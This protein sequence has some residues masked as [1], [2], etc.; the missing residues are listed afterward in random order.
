MHSVS[1]LLA[2][3]TGG[4][5]LGMIPSAD[6][7]VRLAGR[8]D[9]DVRRDGTGNPGGMNASHLLGKR[10]GAAVTATDVG[11]AYVAGRIGRRL[12]GELGS[13]VAAT[14]A[15]VGHCH[16]VG[17]L[18]GKGV[19]ASIGHVAAT[20]PV[21]LPVDL[22]VGAATSAAPWFRQRTRT[23]T[24][25]ASVCWVG[26]TVL[27]WRRGLPNPGGTPAGPSLVAGAAVSSLV[28]AERFHAEVARVD[29][30]NA[31][32]AAEGVAA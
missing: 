6:A 2:A 22:A 28:I 31:R 9:L 13:Q 32:I 26:A 25:V 4:Y 14:A 3:A 20:F 29:A 7:A 19:A 21:Y 11:K 16:P 23:A 15:V 1:R 10:W 5:I 27:W 30:Y 12:A 8:S 17:R 18:G 24:T